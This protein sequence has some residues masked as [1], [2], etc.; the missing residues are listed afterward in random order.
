MEFQDKLDWY[1]IYNYQTLSKDFMW[2]FKDTSDNFDASDA[3]L[4]RVVAGNTPASK[5]HFIF[6]VFSMDR[7]FF[8]SSTDS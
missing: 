8:I 7:N 1:Y 3:S 2:K 4:A 6:S 5:G